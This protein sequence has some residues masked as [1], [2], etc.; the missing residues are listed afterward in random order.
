M[1]YKKNYEIRNTHPGWAVR[2]EDATWLS[3]AHGYIRTGSASDAYIYNSV[4]DAQKVLYYLKTSRTESVYF[5]VPS[6]IV[7]AWQP[8]CEMLRSDVSLLKQANAVEYLDIFDLREE[9]EAIVSKVKGWQEKG[10]KIQ[11]GN[12]S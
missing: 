12:K 2:F 5:S 1:T 10:E 9:L 6:E 3:G 8:L 11:A 4:E 7:E